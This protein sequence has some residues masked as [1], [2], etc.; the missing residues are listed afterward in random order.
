MIRKPFRQASCVILL[1]IKKL[2]QSSKGSIVDVEEGMV[3]VVDVALVL[4]D[5]DIGVE[6]TV[7][8]VDVDVEVTV[9]L[10]DVDV[11]VEVTVVLV[12]VNV[13]V[14]IMLVDVDVDVEIIPVDDDVLL[15]ISLQ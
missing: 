3:E 15:P 7:V 1:G 14:I 4:V 6:G 12:D 5:V 9:V 11:D 10:V 13:E 8:L 2:H